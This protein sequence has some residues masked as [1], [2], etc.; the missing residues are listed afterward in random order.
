MLCRC[1]EFFRHCE[2]SEAIQRV[3]NTTWEPGLLR[4]ARK[5]GLRRLVNYAIDRLPKREYFESGWPSVVAYI[6]KGG[7]KC[8]HCW[9]R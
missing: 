1:S 6:T 9:H 4:V 7:N 2:R 8:T 5:D 3:Y